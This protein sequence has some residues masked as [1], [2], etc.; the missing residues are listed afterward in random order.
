MKKFRLDKKKIFTLY[1]FYSFFNPK[2]DFLNS[3]EDE[4]LREWSWSF[5]TRESNLRE[6]VEK[7]LKTSWTFKRLLPL[8]KAILMYG[9]YELSQ[10]PLSKKM[11]IDQCINFSKSYLETDKHKYINKVLDL[12]SKEN[13]AVKPLLL[14]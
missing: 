1:N 10:T 5:L 3:E 2:M 4:Y 14:L 12:I 9:A 13:R 6:A 11:I 7:N 8:E